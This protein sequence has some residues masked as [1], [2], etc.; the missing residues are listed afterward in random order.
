METVS[1]VASTDLPSVVAAQG[2]TCFSLG[3]AVLLARQQVRHNNYPSAPG[4]PRFTLLDVA[5]TI[6]ALCSAVLA[7]LKGIYVLEG[8][9]TLAFLNTSTLR[10]A[11]SAFAMAATFIT[12]LLVFLGRLR[13]SLPPSGLCCALYGALTVAAVVDLVRFLERIHNAEDIHITDVEL[14]KPV[15]VVSVLLTFTTIG[16]FVIAGLQDTV[17]AK[18]SRVKIPSGPKNED[19]MSPFGKIIVAALFPL[20]REQIRGTKDMD[21]EFPELRRG[22]RCKDLVT[23][24]NTFITRGKKDVIRRRVFLKSMIGVL[25]VDVVRVTVCTL[26]YFGCLLA[27]VPALEL[28]MA[29]STRGDMTAAAILLVAVSAAEYLVSVY[30]MDIIIVFGCRMR[31]MMQGAIFNKAVHMPATM[32]NTYPTGAVVSL[33]AVDCGTLA[34]SVM[35]FPM[36]IGGLITMPVVLWLLAERAGTYPTLCCLAWMIA[37]FLMP[38]GAFKFQRKFWQRQMKAR[39]ERIKSLSDLFASIR[40]VKMYAWEEALQETVHRLRN[41]ELSWLFRANLLDGVLDSV[42]TAS[43]S[44]LTIILFSAL[45]FFEPG[46][47]LKPELSFSCLYLLYVTELTLCSTALLFRNGRQ[48]ALGLG[49]ISEFCT[50][51][52]QE[53]H[54]EKASYEIYRKAGHVNLRKCGF[55][56]S[57]P[58][59]EIKQDH[60]K[61]VNLDVRPGSLVGVVGFVGSGKSSLLSGILGEMPC[62]VGRVVCTGRI[63]YVPQLAHVHNMTVRDNILYGQPMDF[64]F[65][66]EVI[67]G[68]RLIDDLNRLPAGD[69]TEIGEKGG[70]LSGGQKQRISLARAVYSRSDVYLLDDPL[71]SL[72]PVVGNGIFETVIGNTGFLGNKTRIMVCN[73]GSYLRYMD[74]LVLVH[75]GSIRVYTNVEDLLADPDSPETLRDTARAEVMH[76]CETE[77]PETKGG[78]ENESAGRVTEKEQ[79]GSNK[80]AFSILCALVGL[81]GWQAMVALV[82]FAVSATLLTLQQLWIKVWTDVSS[83]HDEETTEHDNDSA[84]EAHRASWVGVLVALCVFDVACRVVGGLLLAGSSRC[85]SW[86]LHSAMLQHVLGSPVSLFDSSPRGRILNRFSADMDFVD[87]RTFLSGKQSVQSVLFTVAKVVVIATQSPNVLLV[88]ALTVLIVF[89]GLRL[90][91]SASYKARFFESVVLSRLLAH[92]TETL[93]CLS[94]LRAYGVV[95]RTCD[96]FCRLADANTRGYSAFCDTYKFTRFITSTCGFVVVLATLL[97]NVVFVDKWDSSRIGLAMSSASSV[98]LAMMYLC[99]LLFNMLQ[100]V[101]SFERCLEYSELPAEPDLAEDVTD[102]KKEALLRSLSDWPSDGAIEFKNYSA[103][104]RPGVLP[105]VL[106]NVTFTVLPM[107]KVG[108]VGRTGAGKS[109]LVL[110]LLRV[111]KPSEGRILIDGFDIADV[112]LKKLRSSITVIPQD[113]SLLRGTLRHNLDPTNSY[114]DEQIWKVLGQVHLVN[115]VSSNSK[116]LLLETGDGGSNLSVGQRQLVCLARA[117]LRNSRLLLLDEA[118]SQMDG[119]TDS[120]IQKTLRESF[121]KY[122]LFTVAHRLHTILDYD[123]ILVMEDGRVREFGAVSTLLDDPGSAFHAMAFEAGV[124]S[125]EDMSS[126]ST[127]AL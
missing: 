78:Q 27:R 48:V 53:E 125:G 2:L 58:K 41:V 4:G 73:Q 36:P 55:S 66:E 20:F 68:C 72:D 29:S 3:A 67:A 104:Y 11:T 65:Y 13:R 21:S 83:A 79:Q 15:M 19:D 46:I 1:E 85:L 32:R 69:L 80:S 54:K 88:G 9:W 6:L 122:T 115:V 44:V 25:W 102:E 114:S 116:R 119:D 51:M 22:M 45:Y 8:K 75:G 37:V 94:S 34:L 101:V 127:T 77:G 47:H 89:F 26:A 49:R 99:V 17:F 16:N 24:L 23:Y 62:T 39:D 87:S 56:W 103:S 86:R 96:R 42:Y 63:A 61:A 64:D 59:E 38:F 14:Q 120:L 95:R 60:L 110:A 92:V 35:V 98:P 33:L 108:V 117:L 107:E 76:S 31:A 74:K 100:M 82:V 90:S 18:S 124:L 5:Q 71:S 97:L 113:P 123:K 81:S 118:T 52:D 57:S 30:H 93:E 106:S 112:P 43:T 84:L 105:N 70:N 7:F 91:V 40:T 111:L 28:L 12:L 50:Q 121:A 109:S 10:L 126:T